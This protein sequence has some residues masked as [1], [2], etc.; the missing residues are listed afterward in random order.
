[1]LSSDGTACAFA[2]THTPETKTSDTKAKSFFI[3]ITP[4]LRS[5]HLSQ[6]AAALRRFTSIR[7]IPSLGV[8][9]HTNRLQPLIHP[10]RPFRHRQLRPSQPIS[11]PTLRESG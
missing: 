4:F 2:A 11:M 10:I 9:N 6:Y 5:K 7:N 8:R 3:D 1:M